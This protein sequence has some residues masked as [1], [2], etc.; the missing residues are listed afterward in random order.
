MSN[1]ADE[2][3]LLTKKIGYLGS[4]QKSWLIP[5]NLCHSWPYVVG[6]LS[7]LVN[8]VRCIKQEKFTN[9]MFSH[10]KDEEVPENFLD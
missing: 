7:W 3:P 8:L 9:I 2:I 6:L 10:K 4:V 5:A 1:Y